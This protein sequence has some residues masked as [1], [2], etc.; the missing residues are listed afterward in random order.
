MNSTIGVE[1]WKAVCTPMA[2]CVAPGPRV[3]KQMPGLPVS[4]P[5][6]SAMFAAAPSCRA[7]TTAMSF[8]SYSASSTGR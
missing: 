6:A 5:S 1:S 3:T 7:L 4:L 8:A 2:A